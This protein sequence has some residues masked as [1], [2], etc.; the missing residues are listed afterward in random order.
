MPVQR[1]VEKL[2]QQQL[3]AHIDM[4]QHLGDAHLSISKSQGLTEAY[5]T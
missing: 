3:M 4:T 2:A 1:V 5:A